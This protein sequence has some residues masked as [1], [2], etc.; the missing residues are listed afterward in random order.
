LTFSTHSIEPDNVLGLAY[1]LFKAKTQG[2]ILG[3]RGYDF[4]EFGQYL[5]E[6]AKNNLKDAV[7][8]LEQT[9]TTNNFKEIN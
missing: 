7:I 1:E 6:K 9:L 5:S 8:F 2:Y 4:N 3:I